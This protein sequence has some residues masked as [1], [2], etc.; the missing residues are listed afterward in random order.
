VDRGLHVSPLKNIKE[1]KKLFLLPHSPTSPPPPPVMPA[2][3]ELWEGRVQ[4]RRT[5]AW[6]AG[7]GPTTSRRRGGEAGELGGRRMETTGS[8]ANSLS[9]CGGRARGGVLV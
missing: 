1:N 8:P 2:T 4:G 9:A 3:G 6:Q 5:W 7:A